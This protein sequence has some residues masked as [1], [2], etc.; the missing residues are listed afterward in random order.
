MS[1]TNGGPHEDHSPRSPYRPR[2]V[3]LVAAAA[4]ATFS[5]TACQDGG[6]KDDDDG[7]YWNTIPES[8]MQ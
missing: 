7:S 3:G 2:T 5:L 6:G 4:A 8:A 1:D